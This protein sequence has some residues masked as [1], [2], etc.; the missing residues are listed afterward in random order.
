VVIDGDLKSRRRLTQRVRRRWHVRQPADP[1]LQGSAG[2]QKEMAV[3]PGACHVEESP[4]GAFADV[5]VPHEMRTEDEASR[6]FGPC[7]NAL[8]LGRDV[9]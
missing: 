7:R 8:V 4:S 2:P 3:E 1:A 5:D 9:G 6:V